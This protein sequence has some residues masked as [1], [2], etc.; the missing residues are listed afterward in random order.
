MYV[1]KSGCPAVTDSTPPRHL[2]SRLGPSCQ[3][4]K[5]LKKECFFTSL[6]HIK[7]KWRKDD[8]HNIRK[9][10]ASMVNWILTFFR[11]PLVKH[12]RVKLQ[13]GKHLQNKFIRNTTRFVCLSQRLVTHLVRRE[14]IEVRRW[15]GD[16]ISLLAARLFVN[17]KEWLDQATKRIQFVIGISTHLNIPRQ[18]IP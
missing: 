16:H 14:E 18:R 11:D 4:G 17:S 13:E 10:D 8:I 2:I 5:L 1:E 15:I 3:G 9:M 7:Y 12:P 6:C